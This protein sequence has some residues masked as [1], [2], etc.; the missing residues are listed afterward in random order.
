MELLDEKIGATNENL[1]VSNQN[2]GS[3]TRIC[4]SPTRRLCGSPMTR[5]LQCTPMLIFV[6][7]GSKTLKFS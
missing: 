4:G 6:S 2:L 3:P 7:P 1:G 5:A